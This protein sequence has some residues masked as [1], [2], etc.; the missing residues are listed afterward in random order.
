MRRLLLVS[1]LLATA[2]LLLSGTV[3]ADNGPHTGEH[4]TTTDACAG[5]HRTHRGQAEKLL[6]E[7]SQ[8]TLCYSC[9]GSTA[10]GAHTNVED[11]VYERR[12]SG[13]QY[14]TVGIGLRGGGFDHALMDTDWDGNAVSSPTTSRHLTEGTAGTM[15]G[16]GPISD[17]FDPGK[18]NASLECG[19]CHTPHGR[20]GTTNGPTYRVL[21]PVPTDS[22]APTGIDVTDQITKTYTL[23]DTALKSGNQYSGEDYSDQGDQLSDWCS[24]CHTR[25]FAPSG[26]GSTASGDVIFT[27]RHITQRGGCGCHEK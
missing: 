25:Y 20:A 27:C 1:T 5:C 4:T 6:K 7:A 23:M 15:W 21:R 18:A 19:N 8:Q 3:M 12:D 13:G 22:G 2:A 14:G 26:S 10:S 9:H 16:N 17:T 24:Q 11:S